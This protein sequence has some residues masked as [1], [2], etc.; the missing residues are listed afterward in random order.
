MTA[1]HPHFDPE[2]RYSQA[3]AARRLGVCRHTLRIWEKNPEIDL[4]GFTR[5]TGG[6]FYL[7][8]QLNGLYENYM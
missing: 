3:E 8:R 5:K 7:G 2:G 4:D 1:V 6:K